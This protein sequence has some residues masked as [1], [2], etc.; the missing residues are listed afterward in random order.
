VER[1][2]AQALVRTALPLEP[3]RAAV[4]AFL[5]DAYRRFWGW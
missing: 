4:D 3:D 1:R 2:L 5:V